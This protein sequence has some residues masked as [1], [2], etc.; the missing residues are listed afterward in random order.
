MKKS[1]LWS[2]LLSGV[3]VTGLILF[4]CTKDMQETPVTE[5]S[6]ILTVQQAREFFETQGFVPATRSSGS[7]GEGVIPGDF[8]PLWNEAEGIMYRKTSSVI[9]PIVSAY[10]YAAAVLSEMEDVNGNRIQTFLPVMTTQALVVV[11]EKNSDK[12]ANYIVTLVPANARITENEIYRR[13]VDNQSEGKFSGTAIYSLLSGEVICVDVYKNGICTDEAFIDASQP[14]NTA[15]IEQAKNLIS[16]LVF[17]RYVQTRFGVIDIP[18]IV[19]TPGGGGGGGGG[20][21]TGGGSTVPPII[22]GGG[23]GGGVVNPGTGGDGGGQTPPPETKPVAEYAKKLFNEDSNLTE[24]QWELVEKMVKKIMDDCMGGTLYN[25]ITGKNLNLTYNPSDPNSYYDPN[26]QTITLSS[27]NDFPVLTQELFH[28][29]Q[30]NKY[31]VEQER[32]SSIEGNIEVEA[33][34]AEILLSVRAGGKFK[35]DQGSEAYNMHLAGIISFID[36]NANI[37]DQEMV[38][39]YYKEAMKVHHELDPKVLYSP[40][41]YMD[42]ENLRE[43]SKNC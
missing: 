24:E 21:N 15:S 30:F 32:W 6:T 36:K 39:Y 23:D 41:D 9:V 28:V 7:N 27:L 43:L 25:Q 16:N 18:E 20:G 26:K 11:K 35:Y 13:F 33:R 1:Y 29:Y 42:L 5:Q 10:K 8:T 2:L 3:F 38:E 19:V 4:S 14:D 34:I 31:Y 22:G 12:I 17:V 37:R 40:N